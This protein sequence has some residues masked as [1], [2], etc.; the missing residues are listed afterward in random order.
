MDLFGKKKAA[1]EDIGIRVDRPESTYLVVEEYFV[2]EPYS[3]VKVVKSSDLGEGLYYFTIESE[4]DD[5]EYETYQRMVK[6][7]SKELEPPVEEGIDPAV[8]V[9]KEAERIA[10][11]YSRSL[12]KFTKEGSYKHL[13]SVDTYEICHSFVFYVFWYCCVR[14]HFQKEER[15]VARQNILTIFP[16][17]LVLVMGTLFLGSVFGFQTGM[18]NISFIDIHE[19][20]TP[21]FQG[22]PSVATMI[23]FLLISSIGFLFNFGKPTKKIFSIIGSIVGL[24]GLFGVVGYIENLP[25]LYYEI[26][27][28]SN[29]IAINTTILFAFLGL[30]IFLIGQQ[31]EKT[32]EE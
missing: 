22:R 20:N 23:A 15:R 6:I 8:Y 4:M 7:L 17:L 18:E 3:S 19:I 31:Q 14:S 5:D 9:F 12:G 29:A 13:T 1:E 16:I 28:F 2:E 32:N 27:E 10:E 30:A 24:I 21:I 11:K 26:P 25:I